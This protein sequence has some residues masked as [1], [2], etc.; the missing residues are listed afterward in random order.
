MRVAAGG[1]VQS[2]AG[3][4]DQR[5]AVYKLC[6]AVYKRGAAAHKVL[7][8][9]CTHTRYLSIKEICGGAIGC[10]CCINLGP[11][12]ADSILMDTDCSDLG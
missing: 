5:P 6:A 8:R 9:W 2:A 12:R 7:A 10:Y 1:L 3:V 4:T 11:H